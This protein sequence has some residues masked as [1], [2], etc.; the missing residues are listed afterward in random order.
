MRAKSSMNKIETKQ[1]VKVK[2]TAVKPSSASKQVVINKKFTK[3]DEQKLKSQ[4]TLPD[5]TTCTIVR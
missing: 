1:T 4:V 2:N 3:K 5:D